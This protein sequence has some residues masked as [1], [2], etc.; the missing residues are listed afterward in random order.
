MS[1][2]ENIFIFF[3]LEISNLQKT[4]SFKSVKHSRIGFFKNNTNQIKKFWSKQLNL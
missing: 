2:S 1:E 3:E 4:F